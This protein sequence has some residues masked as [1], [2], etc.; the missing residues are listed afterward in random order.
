MLQIELASGRVVKAERNR[1]LR[2]LIGRSRSSIEYKHR[3]ISAV[4]AAFGLPFIRG[5][6]PAVNYQAS[7]FEAVEARI[8]KLGLHE[9]LAQTDHAA[10]ERRRRLV[11]GGLHDRHA[12]LEVPGVSPPAHWK[13]E[14]VPLN[15]PRLSNIDPSIDRIIRRFDPAARD[16]RARALGEAGEAFLFQAERNRLAAH[17]RDDLA[18][19]VRWVAK[20]DGDGAGF[21]ILSFTKRGEERWLEVKTTNGPSTTPF[22]L[23]ENERRVSEEYRDRFRLARLYDFSRKP[24]AYRMKPP[25]TDHVHLFP[26]QYRAELYRS[27]SGQR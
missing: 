3:N 15:V 17:G 4:M 8:S 27:D 9:K 2:K 22:W 20:E 26:S 12:H 13:Y 18:A 24:A 25:L 1:A 16:A 7:L 11:E 6:K 23:S 5:Y 19:K 14:R 10:E 21:D